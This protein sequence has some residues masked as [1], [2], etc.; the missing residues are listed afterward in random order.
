[1]CAQV[2]T[3]SYDVKNNCAQTNDEDVYCASNIYIYI[4]AFFI[5]HFSRLRSSLIQA[6]RKE[7]GG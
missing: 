4:Y 3:T 6:K 5:I 1:M 2:S 7:K